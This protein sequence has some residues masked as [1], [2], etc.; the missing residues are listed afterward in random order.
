MKSLLT[1]LIWFFCGPHFFCAKKAV[2]IKTESLDCSQGKVITKIKDQ[3]R[4]MTT[5]ER[6]VLSFTC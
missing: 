5:M 1:T 6:M 3:F 2:E 4:W